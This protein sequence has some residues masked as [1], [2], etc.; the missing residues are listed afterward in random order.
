MKIEH[1][2]QKKHRLER[3]LSNVLDPRARRGFSSELTK[4]V[5]DLCVEMNNEARVKALA[6]GKGL[7]HNPFFTLVRN[8]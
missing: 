8:P 2:L 1:L 7:T 6:W 3:C 4:V 5:H